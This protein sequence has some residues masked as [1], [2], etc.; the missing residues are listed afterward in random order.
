M[1]HFSLLLVLFC[2]TDDGADLQFSEVLP[3]TLAF[4][5]VLATTHFENGHFVVPA[6]SH[7]CDCNSCAGHQGRTNLDCAAF[8]DSQY[9]VNNDLLAYVRS[10][11]FYFN[12][13][14]SS[15]LVLFATGFYDRVHLRPRKLSSADVFPQSPIFYH[16]GLNRPDPRLGVAFQGNHAGRSLML[17]SLSDAKEIGCKSAWTVHIS[18]LSGNGG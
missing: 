17:G 3:V 18:P 2:L 8:S 1:C 15:N 12:F 7:N 16:D 6:V 10:N 9:L 4:L 14:S 5:I 13:F 11:L